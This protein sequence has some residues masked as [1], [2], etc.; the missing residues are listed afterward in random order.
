MQWAAGRLEAALETYRESLAIDRA[1]VAAE[2][3]NPVWRRNLSIV[4]EGIG[5]NLLA[6][7][8]TDAALAAFGEA[9]SI[10]EALAAE[11]PGDP[12]RTFDLFLIVP[13]S[14]TRSARPAGSSR[15]WRDTDAPPHSSRHRPGK[16]ATSPR[17]GVRTRCTSSPTC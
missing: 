17:R 10:R 16:G 7:G 13:M 14:P 11:A 2:P 1:L 4:Q 5:L 15:P 3:S 9:L 8:Q 6:Q 12:R